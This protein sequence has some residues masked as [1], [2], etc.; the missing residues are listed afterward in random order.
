MLSLRNVLEANLRELEQL[1]ADH[2][3]SDALAGTDLPIVVLDTTPGYA[4]G[5]TTDPAEIMYN[6][7]IHGVQDMC[8]L[9][10]RNGKDGLEYLGLALDG[11]LARKFLIIKRIF[12]LKGV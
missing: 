6:H 10:I 5:P 8:N 1:G 2:P 11:S 4:F 7:G 12:L 9:L 3:V